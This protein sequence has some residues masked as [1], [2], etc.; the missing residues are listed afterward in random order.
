M[1]K[2]VVCL[3]VI[4][5]FMF[6]VGCVDYKAYD[7]P[8][9]EATM[10]E[11]SLVDEIAQIEREIM[12]SEQE[13][14]E[15]EFAEEE[16]VVLLE[17]EEV[18]EEVELLEEETEEPV[19]SMEEAD[20]QVINVKENEPVVLKVD[21]TDP[22]DD[23]VT[24]TFSRPLDEDGKWQTNYGDAGEY[25]VTLTATDGKLTTEQKVKIIVERVNVPP[26]IT[27]VTD[28]RV[29][30]GK[31]IEFTP[32][33]TDPNNDPVNV[34]ISEPLA[35][36]KFETDHTSSGEYKITVTASD[37]ELTAEEVFMLIVEDVNVLPELTGLKD[38]VVNEG[39]VVQIKPKVTDLDE[40]EVKVTISNPVGDDGVWETTYIDHGE[41][42]ITVKADD[43]KDVV[44]EKI[45]LTVKDVNM[46]PQFVSIKLATN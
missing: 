3:I 13:I 8:E 31:I 21:V 24:Y 10:D 1:K 29:K 9:K 40:D 43:G 11:L 4:I 7:I 44:T 12:A 15:E 42:I 37:G 33:V 39:D 46:P 17:L 22:D 38:L 35:D 18:E 19:S 5:A 16:E 45:A 14:P 25:I 28:L 34:D 6:M 23:L 41:Y 26:V 20:L 36:G 30:E 32:T 2:S 27:P